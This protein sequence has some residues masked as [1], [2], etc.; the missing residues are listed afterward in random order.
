MLE[1]EADAHNDVVGVLDHTASVRGDVRL[2]LCGVDD[3]GVDVATLCGGELDRGGEACSAEADDTRLTNCVDQTVEVG[4][5]GRCY[6]DG[7]IC[8]SL[9]IRIALT[10]LPPGVR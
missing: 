7:V 4:D 6:L 10:S 8:P 9:T 1:Q 3:H 5:G 2:A